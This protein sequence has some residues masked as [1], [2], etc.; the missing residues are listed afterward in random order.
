MSTLRPEKR[1]AVVTASFSRDLERC[2]LLCDSL[3]AN[4][5]GKWRH[6][7]L[8]DHADVGLFK[9]LESKNRVIVDERD[10]L[11]RWLRA[12]N[13]PFSSDKRRIWLSPFTPPLRG[14]HVQQLR[15]LGIGRMLDE[16]LLF[17]VDSDVVL[18]KKFD[19]VLL[20]LGENMRFYRR[21]RAIT[22]EMQ[23][24]VAWSKRAGRLLL[25]DRS[26]GEPPFHD[27]INTLIGWRRDTL[28]A[29]LDHIET[30]NGVSWARAVARNR[31]ISECTIYGRFVDDVLEGQGHTPDP[32]ALCHVMWGDADKETR[33]ADLS[34]FVTT[35]VPGQVGIGVQ[36]FIG[37]GIEEIRKALLV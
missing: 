24:H 31:R 35:M 10:I 30:V 23:E 37:H 4:L 7:I 12:F 11:P 26:E 28:L 18:V 29:L 8:V 14:W 22:A 27:Y 25:P 13:D 6:Y 32:R 1:T 34:E 9:P 36:S 15:R 16:D 33:L 19:P 2:R 5:L 3:D 20:W 17:S 21:D